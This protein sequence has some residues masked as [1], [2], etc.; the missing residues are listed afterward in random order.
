MESELAQTVAATIGTISDK[1]S[2]EPSSFEL[3][4]FCIANKAVSP[5]KEQD[6]VNYA[7]SFKLSHPISAKNL[8]KSGI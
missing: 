2:F 6:F 8:G 1:K 5:P 7:A 3:K 4:K